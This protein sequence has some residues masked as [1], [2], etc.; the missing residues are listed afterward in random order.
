ME[1]HHDAEAAAL[2]LKPCCVTTSKPKIKVI[3]SDDNYSSVNNFTLDNADK[4]DNEVY[5]AEDEVVEDPLERYEKMREEIQHEH[6][7]SYTIF[8][9]TYSL[10]TSTLSHHENTSIKE[11]IHACKTYRQCLHLVKLRTR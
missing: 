7:V 3:E 11:K 5:E 2:V 8:V 9:L 10:L 1:K 6:M 4:D